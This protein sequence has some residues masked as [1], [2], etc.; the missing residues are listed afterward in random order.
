MVPPARMWSMVGA[1]VDYVEQGRAFFS[2]LVEHAG[3]TPSSVVLDVGCGLGKHAIH[4]S[5]YLTS[6]GRYEGFDINRHAIHWCNRA[7]AKRHPN[8]RFKLVDAKSDRYNP[9]ASGRASDLSFPYS[10]N[11][12]DLVFL[13]SVFTHL[14]DED[15]RNYMREIA[16]VLKPGGT[17]VATIYLLNES[18]RRAIS[19]GPSAFK[20]A[21]EHSDSWIEH[22]DPPESAV[23]HEE[24]RVLRSLQEAGL[25]LKEPI[26]YGAWDRTETQDQDFLVC[27]KA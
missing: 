1:S 19:A 25:E 24:A 16:R 7:I 22:S 15:I 17:C 13:A 2:Y 21:I 3:L 18:R 5:E 8:I 11:Q 23:A 12:F 14:F 27:V 4:F 26:R 9:D 10:S 20:F 6:P